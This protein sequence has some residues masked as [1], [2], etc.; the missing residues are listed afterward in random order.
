MTLKEAL[1]AKA[2]C[3][4]DDSALEV[5]LIDAGLNPSESYTS[6]NQEDVEKA[7]VELLFSIYTKPDI[8]EGGF[9]IGH[10]DFMRKLKERIIQ[11]A[12]KYQ[13]TDVLDQLVDPVPTVTGKN[14]W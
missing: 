5:A 14:V 12:S 10:P 7:L 8:S 11:L 9:S 3:P 2:Q 1:Q 13:M 4:V 6:A